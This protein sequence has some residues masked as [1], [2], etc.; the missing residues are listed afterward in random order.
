[1][2]VAPPRSRTRG[3]IAEDG[4]GFRT[5]AGVRASVGRRVQS[6]P[7][8]EPILDQLEVRI[9]RERLMIDRSGASVGLMRSPGTRRPYPFLST[10]GGLT[11]SQKPPIGLR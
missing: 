3:E 4:D 2:A 9:E 8:E 1:M 10:N 11:G 7:A 5:P 6:L